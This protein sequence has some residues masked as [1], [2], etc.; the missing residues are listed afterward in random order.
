MKYL[1]DPLFICYCILW[2]FIKIFR[3]LNTPIPYL[4]SYLTDFLAVPVIA[5][6]AITITAKYI[7]KNKNYT[8]NLFYLLFIAAYTSVV[9]ELIVPQISD[10]HTADIYDVLFY[11]LGALFYYTVHRPFSLKYVK[12]N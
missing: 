1:F 9:F 12:P 7:V 6:I 5:H 8:Y 10:K 3:Y 11:F 2:L 4:N